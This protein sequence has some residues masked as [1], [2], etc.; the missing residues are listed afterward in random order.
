MSS[1]F[2]LMQTGVTNI[3]TCKQEK[4]KKKTYSGDPPLLNEAVICPEICDDVILCHFH[5]C[6]HKVYQ[7]IGQKYI[8]HHVPILFLIEINILTLF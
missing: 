3:P 4:K 2:V 6:C 5:I 8:D 1:K 7:Q